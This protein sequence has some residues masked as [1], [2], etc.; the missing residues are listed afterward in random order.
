[1]YELKCVEWREKHKSDV[2]KTKRT[3]QN[4]M[5]RR[6]KENEKMRENESEKSIF[7]EKLCDSRQHE[8]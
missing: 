7:I 2:D 5:K 8:C 3:E 6:R 4:R 1:M